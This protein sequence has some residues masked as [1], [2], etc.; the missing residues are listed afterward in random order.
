MDTAST[1]SER[2]A[3]DPAAA[4][5]SPT[6]RPRRRGLVLAVAAVAA[7]ALGVALAV[8]S[9]IGGGGD[10][11]VDVPGDDRR[12]EVAAAI[13]S[14]DPAEASRV[15]DDRGDLRAHADAADAFAGVDAHLGPVERTG[16][17]RG[18]GTLTVDDD[19]PVE[20]QWRR[21]DGVWRLASWPA[22]P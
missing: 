11:P 14:G 4:G 2:R 18:R 12:G 10:E 21:R 8:A 15:I 16:P 13:T 7:A 17:G 6:P 9:P 19:P 3:W 22:L 1:P 20:V 5:V